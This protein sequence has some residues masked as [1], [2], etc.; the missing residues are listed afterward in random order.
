MEFEKHRDAIGLKVTKPG[1]CSSI[2]VR[3]VKVLDLTNRRVRAEIGVTIE[4]LC[5]EDHELTRQIGDTARLAGY[6]AI[7]YPAAADP[8][9]WNVAVFEENMQPDAVKDVSRDDHWPEQG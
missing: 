6:D 2:H 3:L 1:L 7:R 4:G 8:S 9:R 5:A